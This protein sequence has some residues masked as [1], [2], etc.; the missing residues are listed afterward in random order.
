MLGK[1]HQVS[2]NV[3][4]SNVPFGVLTH[5]RD[6]P[7]ASLPIGRQARQTECVETSGGSGIRFFLRAWRRDSSRLY[8]AEKNGYERTTRSCADVGSAEISI[9][10]APILQSY[11]L[12]SKHHYQ[13]SSGKPIRI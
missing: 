13:N 10:M 11:H 5:F 2:D 3:N 1:I 12:D 9:V 6:S 8:P 7:Q 4:T